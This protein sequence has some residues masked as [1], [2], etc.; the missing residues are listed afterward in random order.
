MALIIRIKFKFP[1]GFYLVSEELIVSDIFS[2][3]C[4]N[5]WACINSVKHLFPSCCLACPRDGKTELFSS[6]A[7]EKAFGSQKLQTFQKIS[8]FWFVNP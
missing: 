4:K 5:S 3:I 2:P 7:L 6:K 1:S 8:S